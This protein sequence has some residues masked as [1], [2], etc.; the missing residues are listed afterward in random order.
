M[1]TFLLYRFCKNTHYQPQILAL[2]M[3]IQGLVVL[4]GSTREAARMRQPVLK[5]AFLK[6]VESSTISQ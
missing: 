5:I 2:M 3:Y 1:T 4:F 6:S